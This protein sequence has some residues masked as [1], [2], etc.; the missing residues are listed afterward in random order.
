MTGIDISQWQSAIPA[1]TWDF[2]FCRATHD[3][4]GDD[5][6]FDKHFPNALARAPRRGAYHYAKPIVS[7]GAAQAQHFAQVCLAQGFR[8]N[9]DMWALDFE[10]NALGSQ[11][12]NVAW[13]RDFMATAIA[14]LGARCL[15]YV[16]WPYFVETCGSESI[17]LLHEHA[18][19]LPAYGPNDGTW[20]SPTAPFVPCVH[21]FTSR[22]GPNLSGLDLNRVLDTAAWARIFDET[23]APK[24]AP[25]PVPPTQHPTTEHG[26]DVKITNITGIHLDTNG[27]GEV[28]VKDVPEAS[29]IAL[30]VSGGDDANA[31]K[32]YDKVPVARVVAGSNPALVVIEQGE[33]SGVYSLR[34]SEAA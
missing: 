20:H 3:G 16:G 28:A 19:W 5:L 27:N 26:D 21:Q 11:S 23:P 12:A 7:T 18:W 34:V 10:A 2:I 30:V 31:K 1:G 15:L 14:L 32:R 8:K 4:L 24:P 33:P 29:V 9:V 6:M 13:I 17:E 22:G 25:K